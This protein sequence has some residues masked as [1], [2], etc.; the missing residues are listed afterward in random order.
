MKFLV[1]CTIVLLLL[2]GITLSAEA[3]P[4]VGDKVR[5]AVTLTRGTQMAKGALTMELTAYDTSTDSWTQVGT[6]EFN[7]Q[8]QTQSDNVKTKDLIND[9]TIESVITNCVAQG[10][11]L[12]AVQT[13]SGS[14]FDS[15]KLPMQNSKSKGFIW[16][17]RVPFGYS[18]WEAKRTDGVLVEGLLESFTAGTPK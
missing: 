9:A 2:I 17:S 11:V 6:T 12:E 1:Q 18:R 10:G 15:C 3:T 7:G 13:P 4:T 14:V 8:V 5:Y 16:V